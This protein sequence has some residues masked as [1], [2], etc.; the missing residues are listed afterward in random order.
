MIDR[1]TLLQPV[2]D[3]APAGPDLSYDP[4]REGIE[5]AFASPPDEVDWDATIR[6]I[7]AQMGETRKPSA[8]S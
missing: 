3:D 6:A 7:V 8:G 4:A 2:S 1:E 5:Q